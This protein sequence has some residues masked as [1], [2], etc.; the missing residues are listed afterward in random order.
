MWNLKHGTHELVYKT[1]TE[2]QTQKTIS[3]LP[4]R[5]GG[6]GDEIRRL[7]LT[8]TYYYI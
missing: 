7:I 3:W 1:E 4:R 6:G 8:Y 2:S 5:K